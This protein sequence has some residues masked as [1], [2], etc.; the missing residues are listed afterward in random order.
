MWDVAVLFINVLSTKNSINDVALRLGSSSSFLPKITVFAEL[1]PLAYLSLYAA[2]AFSVS[3]SLPF[4][5]FNPALIASA[6]AVTKPSIPLIPPSLNLALRTPVGCPVGMSTP[7]N[8]VPYSTFALF[9]L[10]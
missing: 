10:K 4:T 2:I 8:C 9:I 3:L 6:Y 7:G 5:A 1:S